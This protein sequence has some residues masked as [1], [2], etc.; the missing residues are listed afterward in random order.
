MGVIPAERLAAPLLKPVLRIGESLLPR[1]EANSVTGRVM[2]AYQ[3]FYDDAFATAQSNYASGRLRVKPR[4]NSTTVIGNQADRLATDRLKQ[5]LER[6]GLSSDVRVNR[7]LRD[8]NGS[9]AYRRPDLHIQSE[10][11]IIDGTIGNKTLQTPQIKD[12]IAYSHGDTI[13][14]VQ[15]NKLPT[16]LYGGH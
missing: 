3:R 6:E 15:P 9:G 12:F 13:I 1:L 11:T 7:R 2:K 8:P 16:L 14:I 10:R 5:W 4:M